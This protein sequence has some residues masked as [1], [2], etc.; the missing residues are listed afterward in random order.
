MLCDDFGPPPSIERRSHEIVES[1]LSKV[2]DWEGCFTFAN[3][4]NNGEVVL[5]Y[6]DTY[7]TDE[8]ELIVTQIVYTP[9]HWFTDFF[10]TGKVLD[11]WE[12]FDDKVR[13]VERSETT[14][15]IPVSQEDKQLLDDAAKDW[16]SVRAKARADR[17]RTN[18]YNT[19][20]EKL[21]DMQ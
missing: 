4:K 6:F 17:N 11:E 5:T 15:T 7:K 9:R 18:K 3:K 13:Y 2:A 1:M 10:K 12:G 21:T 14:I 19:V 8:L 20:R 16:F